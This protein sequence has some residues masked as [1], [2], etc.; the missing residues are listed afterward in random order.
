M[1]DKTLNMWSIYN[2]MYVI[3]MHGREYKII[4][5]IIL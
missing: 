4:N 3:Q 5:E 1:V 2:Y